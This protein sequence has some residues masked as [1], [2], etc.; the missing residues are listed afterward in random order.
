MSIFGAT[1]RIIRSVGDRSERL[2]LF[3]MMLFVY[4]LPF[5]KFYSTLTLYTLIGVTVLDFRF[6]RIKEIP[7]DFWIFQLV[8]CIGL[9]GLFYSLNRESGNFFVQ[10]QL[11][12]F[13]FPLLIPLATSPDRDKTNLMLTSLSVSC[14]L[15]V[16]YLLVNAAM[17]YF[18]LQLTSFH[19]VLSGAFF[20]HSF[21]KPLGI[22]AGYLSLYMSLSLF[23]LLSRWNEFKSFAEKGICS[24]FILLLITGLFFLASRNTLLA[25]LVILL[26]VYPF[27]HIKN[28]KRYFLLFGTGTVLAI[29]TVLSNG[30]L[31]SR[32]SGELISEVKPVAQNESINYNVAEPRIVRWKA[33]WGPISRRLWTGYGTGDETDIL[34]SAYLR[35]GLII[36]YLESFNAHNQYISYLIKSGIIGL[37]V[38]LAAFGYYLYLAFRTRNF[39]YLAFLFMLLFGFYTENILDA[40]KG[41]F[42]FAFFN[43]FFG[44]ACNRMKPSQDNQGSNIPG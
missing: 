21:S 19:S 16:I 39:M 8:F 22:H 26:T 28:K 38:F 33:A 25:T 6:A 36:S 7:R 37:A 34:K 24:L 32:F 15:V 10:R 44:Y 18:S 13:I 11:A 43:P 27:Y 41:I 23:Y 4:F 9:A 35:N 40:N 31:K 2:R 1:T 30:Y 20:N 12:I 29:L 42:F 14:V 3:L 17:L 5:D